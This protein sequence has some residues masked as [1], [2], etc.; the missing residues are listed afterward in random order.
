MIQ[1]SESFTM[2]DLAKMLAAVDATILRDG[3]TIVITPR[4]RVTLPAAKD[5]TNVL[6]VAADVCGS[7]R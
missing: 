3:E 7:L 4:Q 6:V 1:L 2:T 5:M